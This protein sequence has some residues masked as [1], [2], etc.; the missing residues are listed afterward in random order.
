MFTK[1][2]DSGGVRKSERSNRMIESH[3]MVFVLL[4]T[5]PGTH[6]NAWHAYYFA[7]AALAQGHSVKPFFYGDGIAVANRL[8]CPAQDELNLAQLWAELAAKYQFEL[9]VCVAAALK[10]GVTDGENAKRHHVEGE[11]L[12]PAFTL[13]GL[14]TLAEGLIEA[15]RSLSFTS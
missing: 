6:P 7:R 13:A 2:T 12:H 15:D 8:S 11:N 5:A 1:R 4:I 10:R 9:P 3:F 14:G